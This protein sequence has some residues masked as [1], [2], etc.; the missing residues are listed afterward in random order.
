M[1][2]F[3]VT[4]LPVASWAFAPVARLPS[5]LRNKVALSDSTSDEL[6]PM[7]K[8]F[9]DDVP[10]PDKTK[11]S[12]AYVGYGA[13]VDGADGFILK[14]KS[15][16]PEIKHDELTPQD[17]GTA[18]DFAMKQIP[19]EFPYER[20]MVD[21]YGCNIAYV[22]EGEGDPIVFLHGAPE[23]SYIWRNIMPY[24]KPY[25]RIIAPDLPGH[26]YSDKPDMTLRFPDY[27][28]YIDGFI[29]KLGL[30]KVT[31]VLHDWGTILG[32]FY[33]SRN[34]D[35]VQGIAMMESLVLPFYPITDS[36]QAAKDR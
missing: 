8:V 27:V 10:M 4:F 34:P 28:N 31:F 23:S 13:D 26:G 24:L 2:L 22:D 25:G 17:A 9:P 30:E 3:L 14:H 1:K 7:N 11:P 5:A 19:H 20:K 6:P 36:K 32:S 12:P 33:A 18:W 21:V 16:H 35:N 15:P 29:E